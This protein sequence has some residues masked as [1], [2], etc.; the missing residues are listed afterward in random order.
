M[1]RSLS[2]MQSKCKRPWETM[3]I[4]GYVDTKPLKINGTTLEGETHPVVKIADLAG[5]VLYVTNKSY[6]P[7]R[8]CE[9]LV[10]LDILVEN[11]RSSS[12]R[13]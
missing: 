9:P 1:A 12:A 11:Y 8:K 10:I 6:E 7:D 3:P 2:R 4:I 5:H 13:S